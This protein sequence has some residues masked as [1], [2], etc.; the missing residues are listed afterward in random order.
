VSAAAA[1]PLADQAARVIPPT[2]ASA[3]TFGNEFAQFVAAFSSQIGK[4]ERGWSDQAHE[5]RHAAFI[6][7][8]RMSAGIRR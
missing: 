4:C 1:D 7:A 2:P 8:I 3:A 5:A 6:G